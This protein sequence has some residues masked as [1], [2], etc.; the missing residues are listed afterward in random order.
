MPATPEVTANMSP[1]IAHQVPPPPAE[2]PGLYQKGGMVSP[3][4][5][6]MEYAHFAL[7]SFIFYILHF[8]VL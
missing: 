8:M 7:L 1:D 4:V 6:G 5:V 3:G 2:H